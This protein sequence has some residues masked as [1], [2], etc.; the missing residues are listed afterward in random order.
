MTTGRREALRE[1]RLAH[2][3]T[4]YAEGWNDALDAARAACTAPAL[5]EALDQISN[6]RD[7]IIG[8]QSINWSQHIYPLVAILRAAGYEGRGYDDAKAHLAE[9]N[10]RISDD[11]TAAN[12][13]L[14][15]QPKEGEKSRDE[16]DHIA[17][18]GDEHK[19]QP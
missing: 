19:R 16:Y 8:G 14:T 2:P 4:R 3:I 9:I 1:L 10:E 7:S 6:I 5:D 13:R 12:A 17:L 11:E 18:T 15:A